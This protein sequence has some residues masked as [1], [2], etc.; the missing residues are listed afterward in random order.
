GGS[1][2]VSHLR[3]GLPPAHQHASPFPFHLAGGVQAPVRVQPW[4]IAH[5]PRA[6]PPLR[7]T[8]CEGGACRV[9]P[10]PADPDRARIASARRRTDDSAGR[11]SHASRGTPAVT[12]GARGRALGYRR[13]PRRPPPSLPQNRVAPA[14]PA[15]E[16]G[17]SNRR[18]FGAAACVSPT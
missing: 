3:S 5:V 18:W 11:G 8:S 4:P 16:G 2:P 9:D 17:A 1:H 6:P 7:R 10:L 13:G 12:R 15:L 14:K